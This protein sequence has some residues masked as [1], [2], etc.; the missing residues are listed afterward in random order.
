MKFRRTERFKESYQKLLPEI[1][2]KVDKAIKLFSENPRHPSLQV[3]KLE[4]A[5]GIWY[6]RVDLHHRLT[7]QIEEGGVYVLRN[8]G[9]HDLT[10]GAP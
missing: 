1:Q 2:E 4:S 9:R 6:L 8:V 7:F 10:L 5:P 3:R